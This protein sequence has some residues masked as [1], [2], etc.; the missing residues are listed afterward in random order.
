MKRLGLWRDLMHDTINE[1]W[2]KLL[3]PEIL[4]SNLSKI[5][6]YIMTFELLKD[7]IEK[8]VDNFFFIEYKKDN[9]NKKKLINDE[10]KNEVLSL[11][12]KKEKKENHHIIASLRWLIKFNFL[13]EKDENLYNDLRIYRN[14]L[15][16]EF[17][18][19]L[20]DNEKNFDEKQMETLI[21]LFIKLEKRW[22]L[23]FEISVNPDYDNQDI[24][25]DDV[26]SGTILIL[27]LIHHIA[28]AKC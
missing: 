24:K 15:T 14:D 4:K 18:K 21:E 22:I 12:N 9:G 6:L 11:L 10:Y 7:T 23:E 25:W 27:S 20:I 1:S 19:Y 13:D 5:S 28:L 8:I 26:N 2:E 3:N 16:H 17:T